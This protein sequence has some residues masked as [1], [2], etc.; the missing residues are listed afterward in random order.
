MKRYILVVISLFFICCQET[1]KEKIKKETKTITTPKKIE[2]KASVKKNSLDFPETLKVH[3][4]DS[5]KDTIIDTNELYN[6]LD[7]TFNYEKLEREIDGNKASFFNKNSTLVIEKKEFQKSDSKQV[8]E[9]VDD[10]MIP[11]EIISDMRISFDNENLPIDRSNY[12]NL[13]EPSFDRTYVYQIDENTVLIE[14]H[15]SDGAYGYAVY[16]FINKSGKLKK[17][18]VYT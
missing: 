7:V 6:F 5:K 8:L 11:K 13:A 4:F 17:M 12:E 2:E 10:D 1:N 16:L 15:N 9:G 3:F 14:M 18:I